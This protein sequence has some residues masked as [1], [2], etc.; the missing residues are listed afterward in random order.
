MAKNQV[1]EPGAVVKIGFLVL[2]VKCQQDMA[3][4]EDVY[5]SRAW[6]LTSL[7]GTVN[8]SFVPHRGLQ[9]IPS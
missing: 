1:W 5:S 7:D 2:R 6:Y 8:Y 4:R 9:R 3:A